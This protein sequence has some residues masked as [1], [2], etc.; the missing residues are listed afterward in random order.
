M[1][2]V[3]SLLSGPAQEW[4][5][6]EWNSDSAACSSFDI[7]AVE[8]QRTFD[9]TKPRSEAAH[10]L[11]RLQQGNRSVLNYSIE[12]R[13]LAS[14]CKWDSQALIDMI[15]CGLSD[16]IKDEMVAR[17]PPS[18][19]NGLIEMAVRI[20]LRIQ[21]RNRERDTRTPPLFESQE[22][23]SSVPSVRAAVRVGQQ[24]WL[25]TH[26]IPLGVENMKLAPRFTDDVTVSKTI[27]TRPKP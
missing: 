16:K 14:S 26:H 4:G 9:P 2:F 10:K 25:L 13:T 3:M 19:L 23:E 20:D 21:E 22:K 1:G 27:T 7:F 6:A 15:Y 17:D 11:A 24:P 18:D 12:F 8:L 5:I